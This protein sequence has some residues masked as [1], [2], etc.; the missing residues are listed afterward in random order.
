MEPMTLEDF[1]AWLQRQKVES[2]STAE[3]YQTVISY[4]DIRRHY[5]P[6]FPSKNYV[7]ETIKHGVR[8]R[9]FQG[10]LFAWYPDKCSP[11]PESFVDPLSCVGST[12][13]F[14]ND[15]SFG[16]LHPERLVDGLLLP[17]ERAPAVDVECLDTYYRCIDGNHRIY[18][19]YLLGRKVKIQVVGIHKLIN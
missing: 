15:R 14:Y 6:L 3:L 1:R 17:P 12:W 18:A 8:F 19:A 10:K 16:Q 9:D 7:K 11:K 2:A 4:L 5:L 13:L